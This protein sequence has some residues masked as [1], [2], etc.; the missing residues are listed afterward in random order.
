MLTRLRL[1][2][3]EGEL[4]EENPEIRR[5]YSRRRMAYEAP[6]GLES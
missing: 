3:G 2:Q 6:L 1:K 4:V 5:V